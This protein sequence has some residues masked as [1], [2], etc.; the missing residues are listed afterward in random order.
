MKHNAVSTSLDCS[1]RNHYKFQSC[2]FFICVFNL[3]LLKDNCFTE[4][5][6]FMSILNMDQP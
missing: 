2:S 5:C 4:F 1:T 3:F 6:C